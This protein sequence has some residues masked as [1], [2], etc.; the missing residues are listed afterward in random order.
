MS[1]SLN[2]VGFPKARVF[3][4]GHE[5]SADLMTININQAS[6]SLE[7]SPSTATITLANQYSQYI[8]TKNDLAKIGEIKQKVKGT[9]NES[10]RN[11]AGRARSYSGS[12][13]TP[14]IES[15]LNNLEE[16]SDLSTSTI[17]ASQQ[18]DSD[19]WNVDV[20]I[21]GVN[22]SN[23]LGGGV[24]LSN[25]KMAELLKSL[26]GSDP[27]DIYR[28]LQALSSSSSDPL[29]LTEADAQVLAE[30]LAKQYEASNNKKRLENINLTASNIFAAS[31]VKQSVV[32]KKMTNTLHVV[33]VSKE[34]SVLNYE[35][36]LRYDY[37]M[38]WGDCIF[39][40]NDPIRIAMRDPF[41]PS[42][43]YWSFT[44]FVDS[45]TESQGLQKDSTVTI[46]CT[47]VTKMARYATV[48][49]KTGMIYGEEI[50][51]AGLQGAQNGAN[52]GLILTDE[53]FAY[54]SVPDILETL[55]FGSK[56]A[57]EVSI[58]AAVARANLMKDLT[59]EEVD[60]YFLEK[61]GQTLESIWNAL[62]DNF[63][64]SE[65]SSKTQGQ[66]SG[67][68]GSS[69]ALNKIEDVLKVKVN[70]NVNDLNFP[71]L[72]SPRGVEFKRSST[73]KG[74]HYYII[75]EEDI[76]DAANDSIQLNN[77]H[78]WN[79]IIHH[80]VKYTDLTD[81]YIEDNV[82]NTEISIDT[83]Q[84][85]STIGTDIEKYPV[86]HGYVYY[87]SPGS[88]NS[89][90]GSNAL[91]GSFGGVGT[92]H[93][94]FKDRLSYIYDLADAIDWRFYATPKG[95]IV[96][97]MPFYDYDPQ[98]FWDREESKNTTTKGYA[99]FDYAR[100]FTIG[101]TDLAS[102]STTQ[103]DQGIITAYRSLVNLV[104]GQNNLGTQIK[105]YVAV[106]DTT[107]MPT[108]GFRMAEDTAWTFIDNKYDAELYA[109][110]QLNKVNSAAKTCSVDHVPK[111]G[112]M[113]NRPVFW[114]KKGYYAIIISL[115]HSFVWNSD[116]STSTNLN[117]VR[118]WGGEIDEQGNP[119]YKHY[120]DTDRPFN[121]ALLLKRSNENIKTGI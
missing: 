91:D 85:I 119:I 118:A 2:R 1:D 47:D 70:S 78:E 40:S 21:K 19:I 71:T 74:L 89:I 59:K 64:S 97:E 23:P 41:D 35:D 113:T 115:N 54:M 51:V 66:V 4:Y 50:P 39:H 33:A 83:D 105:E 8:L 17:S 95:D 20:A 75:G 112:L 121:L 99:D 82:P 94:S 42:V 55:F 46:S 44:G 32:A 84:I 106:F 53:L 61:E 108:L 37:P 88:L 101:N 117:N 9:W 13:S 60:R 120:M 49:L 3:I 26:D 58:S 111:F 56:S 116:I 29:V 43:W 18:G 12:G 77:L 16:V 86:G 14:S 5:V 72:T 98:D 36:G 57:K 38:M 79:E 52:L 28:Q 48:A 65:I 25:D 62:P 68:G 69:Y 87:M 24:N 92:I 15:Y 31:S 103:T 34:Q 100:M 114:Q 73:S 104:A 109:A 96:F 30:N 102:F 11:F 63:K 81:M 110:L 80:R 76:Y 7:R 22:T 10:L 107:L 90:I 27:E 6:G 45:A 67:E 93:S